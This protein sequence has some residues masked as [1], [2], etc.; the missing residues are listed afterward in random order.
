MSNDCR[1][2]EFENTESGSDE[3]ASWPEKVNLFGLD[4]SVVD[5]EKATDAIIQSA[6]R[7]QSAVVSCHAAHAIVTFSGDKQLREMANQFQMITPDGQPVRWAMNWLHRA[8]LKDRVY[9]PELMNRVCQRAC[10]EQVKIFFYGGASEEVL[11]AL[12]NN[13]RE[14]Y[15]GLKIVGNYSPPFR[16]LTE[17]EKESVLK[18]IDDSEAQIVFIGLGCPKQDI[19]AFENRDRIRAVQVC[20]GAAFDFHAGTKK[21]APRWMQRTGTEWLYRLCQEPGRL[22]KRYLVTNSQFI[23]RVT[24]QTFLGNKKNQSSVEPQHSD[25]NQD[26]IDSKQI[27]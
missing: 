11:D 8:R 20:V 9:G 1:D 6:K 15:P 24:K 5:Y 17:S 14:N 21:M 3:S 23:W 16:E 7:N 22:W 4:V 10:D 12:E 13:V 25:R 27:S 18:R 2:V 26:L 19:F